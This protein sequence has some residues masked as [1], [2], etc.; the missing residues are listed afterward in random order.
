[1][2]EKGGGREEKE[3]KKGRKEGEKKK[4]ERLENQVFAE[5][6]QVFKDF[7]VSKVS[8]CFFKPNYLA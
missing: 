7:Q 1:M 5:I 4:K 6:A 3:R 8:M 2:Q